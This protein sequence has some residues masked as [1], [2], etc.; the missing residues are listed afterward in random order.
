MRPD[1]DWRRESP[2]ER[3]AWFLYR[4][5]GWVAA[6]TAV[7]ATALP[8]RWT[9]S[10][11]LPERLGAVPP[12]AAGRD[13]SGPVWLHAASVGEVLSATALVAALRRLRPGCSLVVSTTTRTGRETAERE[14]Q[15]ERTLLL[16]LDTPSIVQRTLARIRP[17]LLIVVETEF[18]PALY[19]CAADAGIPI[20][21]VSGRVSR[22]A[23]RRYRRIR[24][25]LAPA[26]RR[27]SVFGMQTADDRDR[28]VAL[29][30]PAPRVHVSGSLKA[31][32]AAAERFAASLH[33][34][35]RRVLIAASTHPGE[36][37]AALE[38]AAALWG[39]VPDLLLVLAPRRPER[40]DEVAELL[41]RRGVP[42]R[43]RTHLE[44]NIVPP[45]VRV[46][47][48]D[49]LG[50]LASLY[51]SAVGAFVG[52]TLV[53]VGGH[54]VLEPALCG[55]PVCF[56]PHTHNVEEAAASLAAAG[57]G[58]R[59]DGAAGLREVW[60]RWLL[61]PHAAEREGRRAVLTADHMA[62]SLERTWRIVEPLLPGA[63][64]DPAA[65]LPGARV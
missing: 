21:V 39:A 59:V 58:S 13:G 29:G 47:L 54:N 46:L 16:P 28:I 20:A 52:G 24:P 10:L 44:G 12:Q 53:P 30:A 1:D 34:G 27:V 37:E 40:F 55:R 31:A 43:R 61:V 3:A 60:S 14:I 26:L 32:R 6:V 33:F 64:E 15:P 18:W 8:A 57:G 17:V 45:E 56:G 9:G 22:T 48:L 51:P 65:S 38:A 25:L 35:S 42:F 7:P 62:S 23:F 36:E 11:D 41:A 63:R 2:A 19:R 50:E 5:L 49:T 4:I